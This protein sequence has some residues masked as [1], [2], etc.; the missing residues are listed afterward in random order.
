MNTAITSTMAITSRVLQ[1]QEVEVSEQLWTEDPSSTNSPCNQ[2][3]YSFLSSFSS[4]SVFPSLCSLG[5]TEG[6]SLFV[7]TPSRS[8]VVKRERTSSHCGWRRAKSHPHGS[9]RHAHARLRAGRSRWHGDPDQREQSWGSIYTCL[10]LG[11][12]S[13]GSG[14]HFTQEKQIVEKNIN[15]KKREMSKPFAFF[16]HSSQ[17]NILYYNNA[18]SIHILNKKHAGFFNFSFVFS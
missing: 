8:L 11:P 18:Y 2:F 12:Q 15:K 6:R 4:S 16:Y 1:E 3:I 5:Q 13:N 10:P 7:S 9:R 14:G 17:P